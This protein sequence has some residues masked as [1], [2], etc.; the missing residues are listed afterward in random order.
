MSCRCNW[1]VPDGTNSSPHSTVNAI[2]L[3]EAAWTFTYN[4]P[5]LV[6]LGLSSQKDRGVI[7]ASSRL[8]VEFGFIAVVGPLGPVGGN[9]TS[10]AAHGGG[11]WVG[12]GRRRRRLLMNVGRPSLARRGPRPALK[13]RELVYP[14]VEEG[15]ALRDRRG[16]GARVR[17][18]RHSASSPARDRPGPVPSTARR[19]GTATGVQRRRRYALHR[20]GRRRRRNVGTHSPQ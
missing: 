16:S 3:C 4:V 15:P 6:E 5:S 19:S 1:Q 10:G 14:L 12:V 17:R 2:A 20:R 8:L 18:H 11:R 7:L 9:A 13:G